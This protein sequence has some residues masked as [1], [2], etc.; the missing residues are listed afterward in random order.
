VSLRRGLPLPAAPR[1]LAPTSALLLLAIVV[2]APL[3]AL[4]VAVL[5]ALDTLIV[6]ADLAAV[7]VAIALALDA[8]FVL[9][10]LVAAAVPVLFALLLAERNVACRRETSYP[11]HTAGKRLEQSAAIGFRADLA[12]KSVKS[13]GVH[14]F[15]LYN[16]L[17][18]FA[19]FRPVI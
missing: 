2:L 19:S 16:V 8:L 7:A 10:D 15:L 18:T 1:G 17:L 3:V 14:G 5:L 12:R 13:C 9:A 6:V 11:E 4:A